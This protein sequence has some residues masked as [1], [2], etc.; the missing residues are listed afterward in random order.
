MALNKQKAYKTIEN[1][2][3]E[4][5]ASGVFMDTTGF[6]EPEKLSYQGGFAAKKY[7]PD[8]ILEY[9]DSMDIFSIE[10]SLSKKVLAEALHKWILFS[11]TA[12]KNNG[13]FYLVV[14]EDK[15]DDF[16]RIIKSK[17]ISAEVIAVK[18]A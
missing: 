12:K 17:M 1:I 4:S 10:T 18:S 15:E 14:D 3:K 5:N 9:D 2:A 7:A 11:S 13:N 16:V 8:A 6:Q